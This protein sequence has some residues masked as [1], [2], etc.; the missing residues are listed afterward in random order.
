MPCKSPPYSLIRAQSFL[1]ASLFC[2]LKRTT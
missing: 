1:R 2:F